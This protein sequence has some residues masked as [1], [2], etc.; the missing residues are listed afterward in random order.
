M[1]KKN[2]KKKVNVKQEKV[3]WKSLTLWA[4]ILM[5][6][7]AVLLAINNYINTETAITIMGIINV[8]IRVIHTK[9]KVLLK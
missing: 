5:I 9:S 7:S 8:V 3:W 4:N 6:V 2:N 1:V